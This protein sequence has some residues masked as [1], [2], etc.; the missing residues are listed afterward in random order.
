MLCLSTGHLL[1][2]FHLLSPCSR[3]VSPELLDGERCSD[4]L[5]S[6]FKVHRRLLFPWPTFYCS[7]GFLHNHTGEPRLHTLG[8]FRPCFP[9]RP[10]LPCSRAAAPSCCCALCAVGSGDPRDGYPLRVLAA[11][12]CSWPLMA[13]HILLQAGCHPTPGAVL[14]W[15]PTTARGLMAPATDP[16][17]TQCCRRQLMCQAPRQRWLQLRLLETLGCGEHASRS[18]MTTGAATTFFRVWLSGSLPN[19][20]HKGQK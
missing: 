7:C 9:L 14:G 20:K 10:P 11:S 13:A 12:L 3:H 5:S 2:S 15:Q 18:S 17:H 1:Q 8:C 16:C 4:L 6:D 19:L